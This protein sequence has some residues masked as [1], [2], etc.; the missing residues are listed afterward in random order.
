VRVV[1]GEWRHLLLPLALVVSGAVARAQDALGA[2]EQPQVQQ[3]S[4]EDLNLV[5]AETAMP[6]FV[7]SPIDIDSAF[8]Q[9]PLRGGI[10]LRGIL[11]GSYSQN[12]L[13]AP[14]PADQQKYVG[15]REFAGLMT[16]WTLTW[17]LR[18]LHLEHAQLYVCGVW[19]WVSWKPAGPSSTQIYGLYLYKSFADALVEV[20]AGYIGNNLEV[21][22]LTVGGSTA[23]GAQG[24]YAVLPYELGLSYFPMTAPSLNVRLRGP[25]HTY[26]KVVEQRS[27]D[28]RGGPT[29]VA[30]NR[31]GL[32]FDPKG[33]QLL[34]LGEAGYWRAASAAGRETWLR[35]GCMY[36]ST[37][38]A[39][40][41]TGKKESGNT[42]AFA[43]VDHQLRQPDALHP[44]RGL[45]LG[46]T[47]MMADSRFN[48][49]DRYYEL[50]LYQKAPFRRRPSDMA[51]LVASYTHHSQYL[52]D[53]LAAAGQTVWRH[54][55][56]LTGSYSLRVHPGQYLS[57]GL[58]Y[59]Y[60]PTITPRAW[61][62]LVFAVSYTMFI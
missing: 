19:N 17:D 29:E 25:R 11:Q 46:G 58:S 14:V 62:A 20:K 15:E 26:F 57:I 12:A 60:G 40:L 31:S 33:D 53:T 2:E 42:A 18:Q 23:T 48:A 51:S 52:T 30:R 7:E 39:S 28:P 8:R 44:E 35:A 9:A 49:Y 54:S 59:L 4:I 50:R 1:S 34:S 47:A 13:Q 27:L 56:S 43:L 38:Y 21:I 22:G 61:D 41:D 37:A 16:N 32:R 55:A 24:V 10:A 45:Y 36:N 5:G 6:P 3:R